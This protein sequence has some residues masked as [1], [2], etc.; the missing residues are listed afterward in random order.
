M[1]PSAPARPTGP[2]PVLSEIASRLAE[3]GEIVATVGDVIQRLQFAF[4]ATEVSLW[5]Y[6]GGI[7]RR[8]AI[9]GAPLL[10]VD[11]VQTAVDG[12]NSPPGVVAR[13]LVSKG[14]RIGVLAVGGATAMTADARDV[15]TIVANLLAT[16]G[17]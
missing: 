5:L 10:T 16:L 4:D 15:L 11:D 6:S 8:S 12:T 9:A 3:G 13:R 14:Q 17:L 2:L 1:S 7:L